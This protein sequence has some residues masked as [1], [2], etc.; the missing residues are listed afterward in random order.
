MEMDK[1]IGYKSLIELLQQWVSLKIDGVRFA[2]TY[3]L[4]ILLSTL[5]VVAVSLILGSLILLFVSAAIVHLLSSLIAVGWA[6]LIVAGCYVVILAAIVA[7][8]R[9]L[10]MDA[11][12]RFMSRLLLAEQKLN[13]NEQPS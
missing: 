7:L 3:R 13:D 4:T 11:V 10:I 6:Y 5:L 9:R 1:N 12:A 2:V 8:R